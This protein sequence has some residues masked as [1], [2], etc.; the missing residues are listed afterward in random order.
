MVIA[1]RGCWK[2][3]SEN[4]LDAIRA[5]IR[6][7]VDMVEL[8]VR[9][10]R[11]GKLVLMHDDSVD[12]MTNG[13]G[14]VADIDWAQLRKLR[15]RE[16][17]GGSAPLTRRRIPTFEQALRVA[18][19]RILINVDAKAPL[20]ASTPALVDAV[21][22]RRQLLFKAEASVAMI[23]Q[24]APWARD[25]RFQPILREPNI[26][27]DPAAGVAAYDPLRPVSYEIDVKHAEFTPTI[28]QA[29]RTRCA[30]YW[31]NSLAGRVFDDRDAV[32]DPD[33]V[34]GRMIAQGVDAIQTDEPLAL[35]AYLKR[36][37][38][39]GHSCSR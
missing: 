18:K 7:G 9:A 26:A 17:R 29:I 30:R 34:W 27:A 28:T 11:D 13:V 16:G 37:G 12:R 38:A 5:C 24:A 39:H 31:V 6:A 22:N 2:Q 4:S 15:L 33:F 3:T 32:T 1:H 35:L 36:T 23:E 21:S 8:D 10:T 14:K 20:P 19:N 25:V